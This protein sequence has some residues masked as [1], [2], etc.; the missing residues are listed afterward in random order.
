MYILSYENKTYF[1]HFKLDLSR[2]SFFI[3]QKTHFTFT[4][5]YLYNIYC[6]DRFKRSPG[7]ELYYNGARTTSWFSILRVSA[8]QCLQWN[9]FIRLN[10]DWPP[11]TITAGAVQWS[12]EEEHWPRF[13]GVT[14]ALYIQHATLSCWGS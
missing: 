6:T 8:A 4:L 11:A 1:S 13:G 14:I 12:E 3:S 5:C 7:I 9:C 10:M 2:G